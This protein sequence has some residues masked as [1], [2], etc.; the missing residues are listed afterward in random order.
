MKGEDIDLFELAWNDTLRGDFLWTNAN[1]GEAM[2]EVMTP[3]SWSLLRQAPLSEWLHIEGSPCLGNIGGRL[4]FNV[5]VLASILHAIGRNQAQ[6][7]QMLEGTFHSNFLPEMAIPL[8]PRRSD[9]RWSIFRM[10]VSEQVRQARNVR[11]LGGLLSGTPAWCKDM[12]GRI[13]EAKNGNDMIW[14][15]ERSLWPYAKKVWW[16]VLGSAN[17]FSNYTTPLYQELTRLVGMEDATALLVGLDQPAQPLA[18][19]GL[20]AGLAKV[21]QGGMSRDEF[22][23]QNGHRGAQEFELSAPRLAEDFTW[24]DRQLAEMAWEAMEVGLAHKRQRYDAAVQRLEQ[25]Y[26]KAAR[27]LR[28]RI[29]ESARRGRMREAARSELARATAVLRAWALRA[30]TM[31]WLDQD[32]FLLSIAEILSA[33]ERPGDPVDWMIEDRRSNYEYYRAL[34][35]YPAIIRGRF[36]PHLWAHDP[37]RRSDYYDAQSGPPAIQRGKIEIRGAAGS[38]GCVEGVV[39]RLDRPEQGDQFR[40]GEVLVTSLTNIHWT[41]LFPRAAAVVTDV[42]APLS[43]AAIVARELGIPAVVGCGNATLRLKTGDRVRVDGG[44]GVVEVVE[45]DNSPG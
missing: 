33:L 9:S 36:R 42:G 11:N 13:Q 25:R 7:L 8:I 43:H 2:P 44:K 6:I 18:S 12:R 40:P 37:D 35:P 21:A 38:A 4:Y 27:R 19:L 24:I 28:Q 17:H 15:W 34:P 5:S 45:G 31:I 23:A 20:V 22:L 41:P 26:P 10:L 32:V 3:F 1:F 16:G 30:G 39:R 29:E 14:L